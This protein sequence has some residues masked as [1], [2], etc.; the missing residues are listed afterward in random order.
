MSVNFRKIIQY[1]TSPDYCYP[2]SDDFIDLL[3]YEHLRIEYADKNDL[4]ISNEMS[5]NNIYVLLDGYC[6]TEKYSPSGKLLK[7]IDAGPI[8]LYGLFEAVHPSLT[9]H[10]ASI[11]CISSC[12]YIR[13]S[14]QRYIE[15]LLADPILGWINIQYL[16]AFIN[17]VLTENDTL[18]LNN[19]RDKLL[20]QLYQYCSGTQFP[21]II[22]A[23]KEELAQILNISLRTLYRQLDYLY[24]EGLLSS[25]KGK[26][27]ITEE[28]Y[29]K[30]EII[31][32]EFF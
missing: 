31:L 32:S 12:A 13:I 11:R 23:K 14:N 29:H 19:T 15:E 24:Q 18:L 28:Q 5:L 4:L 17:Q 3:H 27:L 26:I 16:S 2:L 1:I 25:S 22:K 21:I 7:S 20:L 9:Q 8:Q 6:C 30:I 10:T